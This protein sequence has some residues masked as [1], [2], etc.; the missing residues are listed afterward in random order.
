MLRGFNYMM[1]IHL[2]V[3]LVLPSRSNILCID[4]YKKHTYTLNADH[5]REKLNSTMLHSYSTYLTGNQNVN[6]R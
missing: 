2:T 3:T 6:E 4:I 5:A 1:Q